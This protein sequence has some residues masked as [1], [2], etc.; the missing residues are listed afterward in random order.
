M[1]LD[2]AVLHL[3]HGWGGGIERHVD[4]L[5]GLLAREGI[6]SFRARPDGSGEALA[7]SA[8]GA[9]GQD[10]ES[11]RLTL[12]TVADGAALLGDLGIGHAHVHSLVGYADGWFEALPLIFAEAGIAYDFTFHDYVALCPRISMIDPGLTYCDTRS[13]AYCN[14]CVSVGGTRFGKVEVGAWRA[15]YM[16]LLGGARRLFAPSA[17][18]ADRMAHYLMPGLTFTVRPHPEVGE[19]PA[20]PSRTPTDRGAPRKIVILGDL[21]EHKGLH[22]VRGLLSDAYRRG[23]PLQFS[24]HGNAKRLRDLAAL[25]N[26]RIAGP[27]KEAE[28]DGLL[29]RERPDIFLLP[30]VYPETYSYTLSIA[31]KNGLFPV[32]FDIG[33]PPL[34][35]REAGFGHVVPYAWVFDPAKVNDLL[36]DIEIGPAPRPEGGVG[37]MATTWHG[38][39][40]FYAF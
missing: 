33:T 37:A 26:V 16:H 11:R 17:D 4:E 38:V 3:D 15:K 25:P 1:A 22:V 28:I 12:D 18:V 39:E 7:I 9:Q 32:C 35:I 13:V 21:G 10:R 8:I 14:H 36:R 40:A 31:L 23:L 34:R 5:A 30:S 24:I 27:Y 6:R 29:G 2:K 20:P 19:A